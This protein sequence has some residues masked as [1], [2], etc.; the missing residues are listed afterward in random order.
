MTITYYPLRFCEK[1]R[2]IK[3][4]D[5]MYSEDECLGCH[6]TKEPTAARATAREA[7][8]APVRIAGQIPLFK[9]V[10]S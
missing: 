5:W 6:D 4:E 9:E 7:G 3:R 1:C 10:N 8:P 2:Q